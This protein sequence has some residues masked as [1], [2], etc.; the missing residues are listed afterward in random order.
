MDRAAARR[1]TPARIAAALLAGALLA[2]AGI[3]VYLVSHETAIVFQADLPMGPLRPAAP[4]DIVEVPRPD[5]TTQII[6]VMPNATDVAARP[7][8]I[9]LHGNGA[10]ISSRLNI[11]HY[12]RLRQL[13]LNVIAPEYR[14]YAGT[15]G[16]PT[17]GGVEADGRAAY[18]YLRSR[19]NVPSDRIVAFGWSLGSAVA[20]DVASHVPLAAL[21]LEGAPSSLVDIGQI[22]YPYMPIRLLMRNPFDSIR[23]IGAVRAP[24]LFLHSPEDT[25]VPID[26][27]RKLFEAATQPKEFIE[28]NGGHV[29]A[30]EKDPSFFPA[31]A[32]FLKA[33][34]LLVPHVP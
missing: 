25:I 26:E 12:E 9:F 13:G 27:G 30:A 18:D 11:L 22:R 20:V 34:G 16:V 10:P 17:E 29:Y 15:S 32:A 31:V 14:G 19:L 3:M 21:I 2:Y 24:K 7:W 33:Q 5:G 4:F 8:A 28:V 6:W 1:V 23:K